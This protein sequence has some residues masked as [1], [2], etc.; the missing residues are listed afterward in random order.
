[1]LTSIL[2]AFLLLTLIAAIVH[3]IS[4]RNS[5]D[6][7]P[8][9]MIL[10]LAAAVLAA[11]AFFS[12]GNGDS[13]TGGYIYYVNGIRMGSGIMSAGMNLFLSFMAFV[14]SHF[15]SVGIGYLFGHERDAREKGK[16]KVWVLVVSVLAIPFGGGF[17]KSLS[18]LPN[19]SPTQR[20]IPLGLGVITW[21]LG[22][23]GIVDYM[24]KKKRSQK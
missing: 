21:G 24:M 19:L 23:W 20:L 8:K 22:I 18:M 10:S 7:S 6:M 4:Y 1:M 9:A 11:V 5:D 13:A 17:F 2:V 3:A 12:M 14:V 15:V 16:P